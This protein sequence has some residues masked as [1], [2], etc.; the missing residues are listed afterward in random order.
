MATLSVTNIF[1]KWRS[2]KKTMQA[3]PNNVWQD[4]F[5]FI[6][7]GFGAGTM[8]FAPGTFGTLLAIPFYLLIASLP[9]TYYLGFV[10][11]FIGIST[12]LCE[13]VHQQI[14]EHD[15][16]GVTID[17]FAGFF[18]TMINA[19][20]G[21]AWVIL[22]FLLFRFFDIV[23]PWPIRLLDEKIAN[24]FGTVIDDVVAGFYSFI[25]LQ[26]IGYVV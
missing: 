18:V 7:F 5:T 24:G 13:R 2:R 22:G 15:H 16:P 12:W 23:K 10:V 19:P 11:I 6:A 17:E 25:I 9:L 8:P 1:E 3:L 20:K 21:A 14:G 26:L 4:P